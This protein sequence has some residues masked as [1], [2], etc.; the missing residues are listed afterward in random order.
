MNLAFEISLFILGS[1]FFTCC[2]ILQ[3]GGDSSTS[4]P[5][6][7]VLLIFITLENPLL[8]LLLNLRIFDPMAS[9]VTIIPRR[10]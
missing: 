2:K 9:M 10:L 6:E 8:Q 4:P 5:K 3:H 1:D 7:G